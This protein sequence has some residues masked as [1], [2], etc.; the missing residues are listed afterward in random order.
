MVYS[1]EAVKRLKF[2][3]PSYVNLTAHVKE[4]ITHYHVT[5]VKNI[6]LII[7]KIKNHYPSV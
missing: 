6:K 4:L 7:K 5:D 2:I 3:Y 1:N